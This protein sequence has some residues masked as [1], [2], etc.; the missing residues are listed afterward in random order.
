MV[1]GSC[2]PLQPVPVGPRPM[3][4][5]WSSFWDSWAAKT[6]SRRIFQRPN[7]F[8]SRILSLGFNRLS[9]NISQISFFLL[10]ALFKYKLDRTHALYIYYTH[11]TQC[12]S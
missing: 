8:L 12:E 5:R 10:I 9:S 1:H 4:V 6:V 2:R 11:A 3:H 7:T